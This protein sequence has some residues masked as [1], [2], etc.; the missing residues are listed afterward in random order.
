MITLSQLVERYQ[1]E[2]ERLH[3]ELGLP[4]FYGQV[5]RRHKH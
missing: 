1:P 5:S 4:Q 2:L 3:G